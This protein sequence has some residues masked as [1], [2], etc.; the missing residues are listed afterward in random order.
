MNGEDGQGR[1]V[2][3]EE[4]LRVLNKKTSPNKAAGSD[5]VRHKV[6]KSCAEQLYQVLC[7]IFNLPPAQSV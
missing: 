3:E 7:Y 1:T 6:L 5:G 4:V 2:S